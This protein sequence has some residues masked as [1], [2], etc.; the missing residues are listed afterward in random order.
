MTFMSNSRL[1]TFVSKFL[2]HNLSRCNFPVKSFLSSS[3]PLRCGALSIDLY[4]ASMMSVNQLS[5]KLRFMS[6]NK[7]FVFIKRHSQL[8]LIEF[9]FMQA[10]T[11]KTKAKL[12]STI[13]WTH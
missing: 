12:I 3:K 2:Y 10:F 13:S 5:A 11:T 8:S 1:E 7:T 4:M 6:I 9:S